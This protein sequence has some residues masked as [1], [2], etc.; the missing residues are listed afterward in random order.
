[1]SAHGVS[2]RRLAACDD[3]SVKA[4]VLTR[5]TMDEA[6]FFLDPLCRYGLVSAHATFFGGYDDDDTMIGAML[7]SGDNCYVVWNQREIVPLLTNILRTEYANV[8]I[9]GLTWLSEPVLAQ[10]AE[11]ELAWRQQGTTCALT[12]YSLQSIQYQPTRR[13]TLAD[14]PRIIELERRVMAHDQGQSLVTVA[15]QKIVQERITTYTAYIAEVGKKVV[16]V[17]YTDIEIPQA[18]HVCE[19]ATDPAYRNQGFGAAC[20]AALCADLLNRVERIFLTYADNN[21]AAARTYRK[22]GFIPWSRRQR[23]QL[24]LGACNPAGRS[25]THTRKSGDALRAAA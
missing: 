20:V 25:E 16:A 15:R 19:V 3:A 5:V 14:V 6:M 4:Y 24:V 12:K 11:E 2:T 7:L 9:S 22:I 1:M 8:R 10:F 17:A 13:A 21:T 23:A 18:A